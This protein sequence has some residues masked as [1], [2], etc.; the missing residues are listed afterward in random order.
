MGLGVSI[1][2]Y[3][4][5]PIPLVKMIKVIIDFNLYISRRFHYW[6]GYHFSAS[7]GLALLFMALKAFGEAAD[8]KRTIVLILITRRLILYLDCL[9]RI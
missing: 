7:L 4:L 6:I 8:R 2:L 5:L 3:I 1:R 9:W